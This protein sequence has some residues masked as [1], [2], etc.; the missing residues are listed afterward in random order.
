MPT[1]PIVIAGDSTMKRPSHRAA[2]R[3]QPIIPSFCGQQGQR[4][5]VGETHCSEFAGGTWLPVVDG[6]RGLLAGNVREL[7][8]GWSSLDGRWGDG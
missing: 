5:S 4:Q 8:P 3:G 1:S 6:G 7:C 2:A